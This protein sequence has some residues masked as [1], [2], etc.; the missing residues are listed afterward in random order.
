MPSLAFELMTLTSSKNKTWMR[1]EDTYLDEDEAE[2]VTSQMYTLLSSFVTWERPDPNLHL[3]FSEFHEDPNEFEQDPSESKVE[4]LERLERLKTAP[5]R[6]AKCE[7]DWIWRA[8]VVIRVLNYLQT[9]AGGDYSNLRTESYYFDPKSFYDYAWI[10][11]REG[12]GVRTWRSEPEM[13]PNG[14]LPL[15]CGTWYCEAAKKAENRILTGWYEGKSLTDISG[16]LTLEE[17]WGSCVDPGRPIAKAVATAR[18]RLLVRLMPHIDECHA[19]S[20]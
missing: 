18:T 9:A 2:A 7:A 12:Q 5:N 10:C 20:R 4:Y 13:A 8:Q 16:A 1:I 17:A 15:D 6:Q 14:L 19:D 11:F 3:K